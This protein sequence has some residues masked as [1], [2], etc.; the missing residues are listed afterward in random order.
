MST[1]RERL[2]LGMANSEPPVTKSAMAKACRVSSAAVTNWFYQENF[3][4]QATHCF[5]LAKLM[6]VDPEWLATGHGKM[7]GSA[8]KGLEPR[9]VALIQAYREL[10]EE[11]RGPIRMLIETMWA[12]HNER[13]RA[14]SHGQHMHNQ[15]R[16]AK[17]KEKT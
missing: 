9:H 15:E 17:H 6:H 1:L 11:I 13:Y 16:D 5:A 3:N 7:Q 12:A 2:E 14:W 8:P 4:L 10:P